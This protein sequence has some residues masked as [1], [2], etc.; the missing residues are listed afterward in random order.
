MPL[1][2]PVLML[3]RFLLGI[4]GSSRGWI[5]LGRAAQDIETLLRALPRGSSLWMELLG[6][7]WEAESWER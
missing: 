4:D 3:P 7:S 6:K 2:G 1:R 5:S